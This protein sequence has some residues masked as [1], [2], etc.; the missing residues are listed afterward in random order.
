VVRRHERAQEGRP[1]WLIVRWQD[2]GWCR[3]A[4][5]GFNAIAVISAVIR[6]SFD[7]YQPE[8]CQIDSG[9][10]AMGS[11]IVRNVDDNLISRLKVRAAAHG[12]SAEAEHRAILRQALTEQSQDMPFGV[13][14]RKIHSAPGV[15]ETPQDIID[16]ME[17]GPV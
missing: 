17:N 3:E 2:D 11:L 5:A 15:D 13:L 6:A 14:R 7:V 10:L 1:G 12:R 4:P 8:C 16:I 9:V